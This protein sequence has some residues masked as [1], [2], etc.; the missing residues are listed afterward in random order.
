MRKG[1]SRR[2]PGW[3]I[4]ALC[5][6]TAFGLVAGCGGGGGD[7]DNLNAYAG[8][9]SGAFTLDNG[10]SGTVN[11]AVPSRGDVVTV[12]LGFTGGNASSGGSFQGRMNPDTGAFS[13]GGGIVTFPNQ[14]A[15]YS[16]NISGQ[17]NATNGGTY[18]LTFT[19]NGQTTTVSGSFTVQPNPTTTGNTTGNTT[20]STCDDFGTF[21]G[22]V[23]GANTNANPTSAFAIGNANGVLGTNSQGFQVVAG[24][25]ITCPASSSGVNRSVAF[26]LTSRT[27][28][29][30]PADFPIGEFP[31]P[32]N[33]QQSNSNAIA[34]YTES[35]YNSSGSL[36]TSR[37]WTA[38]AGTVRINSVSG[39]TF[40][41]QL[42]NLTMVPNTTTYTG[43]VAP[44]GNITLNV[45]GNVT[46]NV[47]P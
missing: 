18:T 28:I 19:R 44:F 23:A 20:R 29:N 32:G 11:V 34:T 39:N 25:A 13:F 7:S 8:S 40:T 16:V 5:I 1:T 2:E 35:T 22:S 45:N 27:A 37:S 38:T 10:T 14:A 12:T 26:G 36:L 41:F 33:G 21:S 15:E 17:L 43:G 42:V 4:L 9:Y 46:R 31:T 6:L 24:A 47:S 3:V 30:A